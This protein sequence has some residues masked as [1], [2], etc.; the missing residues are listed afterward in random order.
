MDKKNR[1]EAVAAY[2]A[3]PLQGGIYQIRN[4]QT[5]RI[6]LGRTTELQGSKNRFQ[7]AQ[8]T[9]SCVDYALQADWRQ[10]GKQ[11]FVWEVLETLEQK[12]TQT[13][14]EFRADIETLYELWQQKLGSAPQY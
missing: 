13:P 14:A 1:R 5:G 10:Y 9:D 2:K 4:T 3:T 12:E 7:F 6:L 11:I 8:L